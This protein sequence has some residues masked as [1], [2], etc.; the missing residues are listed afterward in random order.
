MAVSRKKAKFDPLLP[1]SEKVERVLQG[2]EYKLAQTIQERVSE[3]F[4]SREIDF[5]LFMQWVDSE[6]G[7]RFLRDSDLVSAAVLLEIVQRCKDQAETDFQN[8]DEFS[9]LNTAKYVFDPGCE[10]YNYSWAGYNELK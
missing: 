8:G 5:A 7:E 3:V 6:E 9:L 4:N 1:I 2:I 10:I